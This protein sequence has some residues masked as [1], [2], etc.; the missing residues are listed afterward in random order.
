MTSIGHNSEL[1]SFV[2]RIERL[3]EERRGLSSDIRSVFD[4]AK[5]KGFD[6]PALREILKLRR[7]D[8]KKREEL[9]AIV[10]TYKTQLKMDL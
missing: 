2:D 5:G 6:V 4:E 7:M 1:H 9:A 8:A 3:D 10:E